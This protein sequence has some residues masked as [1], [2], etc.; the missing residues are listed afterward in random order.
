MTGISCIRVSRTWPWSGLVLLVA[1]CAGGWFTAGPRPSAL[2]GI[3]VDSASAAPGDTVALDLA[4]SG[5]RRMT[6]ITVSPGTTDSTSVPRMTVRTIDEGLWYVSGAISDPRDRAFCFKRRSRDG[7]T[8]HHF[9]LD[10]LSQASDRPVRRLVILADERGQ[11]RDQVFL[12][13][14]AP[15]H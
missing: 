15:P 2:V 12:E 8:C 10:T 6:H 1:A 7:A 13:R 9:R 3:W 14:R 4:S 11:V 5:I